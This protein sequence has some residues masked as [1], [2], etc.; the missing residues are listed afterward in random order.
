M[1]G[2]PNN[3]IVIVGDWVEWIALDNPIKQSK[4]VEPAGYCDCA[5]CKRYSASAKVFGVFD[6]GGRCFETT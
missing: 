4:P 3:T 1:P 6:G 2:D 5:A